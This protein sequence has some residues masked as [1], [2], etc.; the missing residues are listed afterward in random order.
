MSVGDK[1]DN[2]AEDVSGKAKEAAG[3][4]TDDEELESEGRKDQAA[5]T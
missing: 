4:V 2:A 1:F 5:R 3:K